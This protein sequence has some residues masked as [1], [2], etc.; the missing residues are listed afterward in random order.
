MFLE[1]TY[2]PKF[3]PTVGTFKNDL[4]YVTHPCMQFLHYETG[5][6]LCSLADGELACS[7]MNC[8]RMLLPCLRKRT[9][10]PS[11][12][13]F[14]LY[15]IRAASLTPFY[16]ICQDVKCLALSFHT[17]VHALKP[18]GNSKCRTGYGI[19]GR[20]GGLASAAR[21]ATYSIFCATFCVPTW[22]CSPG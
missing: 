3:V 17:P 15:F 1:M 10:A 9:S 7:S 20:T 14:I 11:T 13:I 2:S 21:S 16:P 5:Q 8:L 6:A 4:F 19:M 18:G 12:S 22:Y